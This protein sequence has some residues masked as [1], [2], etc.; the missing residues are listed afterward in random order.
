[1][2]KFCV[3]CGKGPISANRVSHSNLKTKR[4]QLPNLQKKKVK[5]EGKIK[6]VYVCTKCLKGKKVEVA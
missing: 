6:S 1:M 5:I 4:R 2:S 3:I